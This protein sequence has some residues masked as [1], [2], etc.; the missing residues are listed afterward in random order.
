M[1]KRFMLAALAFAL[2][3]MNAPVEYSIEAIRYGVSPGVPVSA[4]ASGSATMATVRPARTSLRQNFL[5]WPS[6]QAAMIFGVNA[7]QNCGGLGV[8]T[9]RWTLAL[10]RVR[11]PTRKIRRIPRQLRET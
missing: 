6:R 10:A 4:L 9:V 8:A 1:L 11:P 5:T 3:G 2:M 7:L